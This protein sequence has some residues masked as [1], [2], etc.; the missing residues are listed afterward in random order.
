M[1]IIIESNFNDSD[2]SWYVKINGEVDLFNSG[3][4]KQKLLSLIEQKPA[5]FVIDCSNLDYIDSTALG[6]LVAVLKNTKGYGCDISL[7][8]VKP[9]IEKLFK[10]TNLDKVFKIEGDKNEK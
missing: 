5:N 7:K 2:N 4:M 10:I 9:N 8:N 3:E 6:A 1:E